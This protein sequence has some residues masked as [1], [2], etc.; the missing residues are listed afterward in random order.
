MSPIAP[1]ISISAGARRP[2]CARARSARTAAARR[3]S[4]APSAAPPCARAR[5]RRLDSPRTSP[6]PRPSA[7][8]NRCWA[9]GNSRRSSGRRRPGRAGR[10]RAGARQL[11]ARPWRNRDAGNTNAVSAKASNNSEAGSGTTAG[12]ARNPCPC[13]PF[14][15]APTI[16]PK[17]LIPAALLV[18]GSAKGTSIAV[19]APPLSRNP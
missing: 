8:T 18:P 5:P 17:S 4:G 14:P 11:G 6:C 1:R 13:P 7:R 19:K 16:C 15:Y 3:G 2:I 9:T 10:R 12:S